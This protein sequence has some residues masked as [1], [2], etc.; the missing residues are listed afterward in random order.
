MCDE[1]TYSIFVPIF[2]SDYCCSRWTLALVVDH[3]FFLGSMSGFLQMLHQNDFPE[4]HGNNNNSHVV[5]CSQSTV[6]E[7]GLSY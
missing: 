6:I 2:S 3:W 7:V 5:L 1:S 4:V